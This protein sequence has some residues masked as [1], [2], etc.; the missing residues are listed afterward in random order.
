ME[1]VKRLFISLLVLLGCSTGAWAI[2]QDTDGYYLIGSVQDWKDFAAIVETTPKANARM[3]ADIDLGD[4]QTMI[5]T[6]SSQFKGI[7][8]GQGYSI[9]VNYSTSSVHSLAPF[10]TINGATI[11]NIVVDGTI[12]GFMHCS[13]LV[14]YADG[15]NLISNVIVKATITTTGS[16]CGG[17]LGHGAYSST[18]IKD[19]LFAGTINGANGNATVGAI[20]GWSD[21]GSPVII[22]C[23]ENGSYNN[24]SPFAPIFISYSGG[25]TVTN[26]YYVNGS[27]AYGTQVTATMLTDGSVVE[28][29]NNGR[30]GDDAPWVQDPL[31]KQP[32]LKIFATL[33]QDAD[34]YYLIGSVTD[35]KRFAELVNSGTNPSANAKMVRDVDLGDD[36]TRIGSTSDNNSAQHY[37][38]IFDGQGHKLTIAYVETGGSN[39]CAPF[40]KLDGAT[41][42]NLH[43]KGTINTA[44]IHGAGVASD[45][46][47]TTLIQNVWSEVDVTS[48][49]S[50]WDECS[51][52][53]GCMK[54]D[55]LTITDCL[56]SGTVTANSSHN[57]GF[58]GYR[59]SGTASI[60]NCLSTGTFA[61]G[62]NQDFS[63]GATVSN[64]YYTQFVGSVSGLTLVTDTQLADGTI[65]TALQADR[66]EE[67]WVQDPE[68][69]IPML[70]IFATP[71]VEYFLIGS[72][73]D[74]KDFA[75]LV[76][77]EPTT[78]GKLIADVDLG[79][80]QTMVGSLASPYQGIFDGQGYTLT[81]NYDM[82]LTTSAV[83]P[84]AVVGN[85]VIQKL[86]VA[87]SIK[88]Q[89]CAAGGVVGSIMGNVTIKECWVS[90]YMYVQGSGNYQGTIGGIASCCD[91]SNARN[92]T[93][94]IEDCVFTGE[95]ATGYHCGS[96][97]S[98]VNGGYGN[99]AVIKNC[100]ALGTYASAI[101]STGTFIRVGTQG[102]PYSL[103]NCYYKTSWGAVQ[104]TQATAE[105]L[106][107]GTTATDLGDAWAQD[108]GTGNPLPKVFTT[109][110]QDEDGYYLIGS[111]TDWKRFADIVKTTPT[112]NAKMVADVDLGDDQTM[113]GSES[114]PYQGTF[115]GH[116]YKLTI[117][118]DVTENYVAPFRVVN[119]ATIQNL[120][121]AGTINT[122]AEYAGGIIG[123]SPSSSTASNV[124]MCRSSVNIVG[125]S[126]ISG[127]TD[128][129]GGFVG[130]V[131]APV[132]F[133]D[134]LSDGKITGSSSPAQSYCTG[135][136]GL[137]RGGTSTFTNC[138]N[139]C[140]L[141]VYATNG[142]WHF[143][144]GTGSVRNSYVINTISYTA[145][146][147]QATP[148][149]GEQL[150]DGTVTTKLQNNRE[151]EVWVL[152]PILGTPML[153]LFAKDITYTVPSSGIGTFSAKG[154]V[155]LPEGLKAYYCKT[156]HKKNS[157]ISVVGIS[158][159]IVPAATGV[160]LVG[161]KGET[162]TLT[163][164]C[165]Q[166]PTIIDNELVA[167]TE[168]K[169]IPATDGDY[170]NFMMKGGKFIKIANDNASMPANRAY[171]PLLTTAISGSNAKEIMLYWDDEE[172]T[173]IE[174]MRNVENER[175]RNGN[176]YNLNGQK[177]LA[178]QKGINIINGRK[179]IVK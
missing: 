31:T 23:L 42:K 83:A 129:H 140:E 96:I 89:Y 171:L 47:G 87:G 43:I 41:I 74:W 72:L 16:H 17:I 132:H 20:W 59:D 21:G 29:L 101:G 93:I 34:G 27:S 102:D 127:R 155:L 2:E 156:Y 125:H 158:G 60:S 97:M 35:W 143:I 19:C 73:Q 111:V 162:F 44:G 126:T 79:D 40:N 137:T 51:G 103:E 92:C 150:S 149:T 168:S 13:G 55:N 12:A 32:T 177:L 157:T 15:N 39:L 71:A 121:V 86:H 69:G 68:L 75:E 99:S 164:A 11:K 119:G 58:I 9:S 139:N 160:L 115:D 170:T 61:Y 8:D 131:Y 133:T 123:Y 106:A 153:K 52:I 18:T 118:Y 116:G 151:E 146:Y 128:W 176:I 175:M 77:T 49:H 154:Q 3:I 84:F 169:H 179:V 147:S 138:L 113:V 70:K 112:A 50:G 10:Q 100:L 30:T 57:G 81:V 90:A 64:S 114:V 108:P 134:C 141:D 33:K 4:D 163:G 37:K 22:N 45:A 95:M 135:F 88:Q 161:N 120:E 14:G 48:T 62:S 124:T 1:T 105:E 159:N 66:S 80:D 91:N 107:D 78:N 38:G 25:P 6:S 53:V 145:G 63:G 122:T 5:G 46:R 142:L 94:L 26:S 110:R 172:T 173:G 144:G 76:K 98:H 54:A 56:F 82:N 167:V 130:L 104:G 85:A 67:I 65:A 109:M 174:R 152:D 165:G 178:P 7:F 136:I 28:G 117:A 36:Q 166:A 24:C 148:V